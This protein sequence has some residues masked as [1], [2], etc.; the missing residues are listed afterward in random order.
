MI[1]SRTS[2]S[3]RTSL[4]PEAPEV[5]KHEFVNPEPAG[6]ADDVREAKRARIEQMKKE[7]EDAEAD[8]T[9]SFG[10]PVKV[11]PGALQVAIKKAASF[12]VDT[13]SRPLDLD[14][15]PETVVK[16]EITQLPAPSSLEQCDP[17][18]F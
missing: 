7:L 8:F 6:E 18:D 1:F 2:L 13:Q 16:H 9:Y 15:M 5:Q 11:E 14:P 10:A 3:K 17:A 4:N 12:A